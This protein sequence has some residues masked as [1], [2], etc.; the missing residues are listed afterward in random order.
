M[1]IIVKNNY[2]RLPTP[3]CY[4]SYWF[5]K[6]GV[7]GTA[8]IYPFRGNRK[9]WEEGRYFVCTPD[10]LALF[11]GNK[12]TAFDSAGEALIALRNYKSTQS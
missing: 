7:E 9:Q 4:G 5:G 1:A 11:S 6:I 2:N 8:V 12:L 10:G 3:D